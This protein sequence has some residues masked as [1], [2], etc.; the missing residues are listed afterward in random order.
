[1]YSIFKNARLKIDLTS[2]PTT[3]TPIKAPSSNPP[4]TTTPIPSPKTPYTTTPTSPKTPCTTTPQKGTA[5]TSKYECD[6]SSKKVISRRSNPSLKDIHAVKTANFLRW[7][8]LTGEQIEALREVV[9]TLK[10]TVCSSVKE[11]Q[12]YRYCDLCFLEAHGARPITPT[13]VKLTLSMRKS[14]IGVYRGTQKAQAINHRKKYHPHTHE[15]RF[16]LHLSDPMIESLLPT[17]T[18]RY[19]KIE[20]DI[21]K[22]LTTGYPFHVLCVFNV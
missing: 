5:F 12:K 22:R 21:N 20:A 1:M 4:C 11:R 14:H 15:G 2:T 7:Q 3:K 13:D 17:S 16:R 18:T 8:S 19:E 9:G 6:S 10:A